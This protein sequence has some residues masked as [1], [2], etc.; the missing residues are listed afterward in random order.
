MIDNA[1]GKPRWFCQESWTGGS[2]H[3]RGLHQTRMWR[4]DGQHVAT[5]MQDG[6]VRLKRQDADGKPGFSP[7]GMMKTLKAPSRKEKL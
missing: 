7:D 4:E 5:S 2:Q 3:G 6:M 1:T